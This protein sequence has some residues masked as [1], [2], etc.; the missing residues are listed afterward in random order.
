M[1]AII[2]LMLFS[3][4][5]GGFS[6]Y[7]LFRTVNSTIHGRGVWESPPGVFARLTYNPF[8]RILDG[9]QLTPQGLR[10]RRR[11]LVSTVCFIVP[12]GSIL[13]FAKVLPKIIDEPNHKPLPAASNHG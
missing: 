2:L 13:L 8:N 5:A 4:V 10:Y 12:V 9:S 7:Y 11:L 3:L 6:I 1:I